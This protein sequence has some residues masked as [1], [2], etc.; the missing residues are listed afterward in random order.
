MVSGPT[1]GLAVVDTV[2]DRIGASHRI[3][4]VRAHFLEMAGD[5]EAATVHYRVAARLATSLPERRSL[6]LRAVRL[7]H[8]AGRA[9]D[10]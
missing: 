8:P 9:Q 3:D 1:A 6:E 2:V 5:V 7:R 4:A 10:T